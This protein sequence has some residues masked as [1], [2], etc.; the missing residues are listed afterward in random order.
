MNTKLTHEKI[1]ERWNWKKIQFNKSI[2]LKQIGIKIVCTKSKGGNNLRSALKFWKVR[3]KIQD[4]EREQRKK[5]KGHRH[6]PEAYW[7]HT[8][9]QNGVVAET[10][11]NR[12]KRWWLVTRQ[13]CKPYKKGMEGVHM[14]TRATLLLLLLLLIF[15]FLKLPSNL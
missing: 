4:G 7:P 14:Q 8:P 6:K 13:L 5:K 1:K 3:H 10:I 9:Q 15:I 12:C 11:K 2:H